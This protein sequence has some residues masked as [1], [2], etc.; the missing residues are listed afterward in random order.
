MGF[1]I[2]IEISEQF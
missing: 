2:K 1:E